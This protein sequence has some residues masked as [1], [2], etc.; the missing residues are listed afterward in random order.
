VQEKEHYFGVDLLRFF[1]A[2]LVVLNHFGIFAWNTPS[3]T[4]TGKWIAFPAL[5]PASWFGWVGVEIFFVISGFVIAASAR[6]AT[7]GS[8]VKNRIIRVAPAL[9]ICSTVALLVQ[10]T[11]GQP[12]HVLLGSYARSL[13]LSPKGP[14]IDG[15]IWTLVVEAVFYFLIYATLLAGKFE[16]IDRIAAALGAASAAFLIF[17]AYAEYFH[18]IPMFGAIAAICGRFFFK[19]LL[20]RYGVFFA[21]GILLWY[22]FERGFSRRTLA[23]IAIFAAFGAVE[24]AIQSAELDQ[25][26][27]LRSAAVSSVPS[28]STRAMLAVFIWTGGVAGLILSVAFKSRIYRQLKAHGRFLRDVGLLTYPI[29]LNHFILGMTL[30]PALFA[31]GLGRS[32][33]F[34]LSF[35]TVLG[36]SWF[37]MSVPERALQAVLLS[38]SARRPKVA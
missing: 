19:V 32:S 23:L 31:L 10:V 13:I 27:L 30:V 12:L 8:F 36:S 14:Y 15:V 35:A 34:V 7:P 37:I 3:M 22:G 1:A 28:L 20:L 17:F 16:R 4:A 11:S 24:I 2:S 6:H 26:V 29:Y 18:D 38:F 33:V 9:W 5:V 25:I 21:C